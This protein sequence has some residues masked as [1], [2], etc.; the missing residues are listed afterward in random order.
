MYI[1]GEITTILLLIY[2]VLTNRGYFTLI[3]P[4]TISLCLVI[5][6]LYW[7]NS[8]LL[9]SIY[10]KIIFNF[11]FKIIYSISRCVS[12]FVLNLISPIHWTLTASKLVKRVLFPQCGILCILGWWHHSSFAGTHSSSC[13]WLYWKSLCDIFCT[14]SKYMSWTHNLGT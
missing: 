14:S 7:I 5:L 3:E 9:I 10:S 6:Q 2:G 8:L 11:F 12:W 1:F 4:S 13:V